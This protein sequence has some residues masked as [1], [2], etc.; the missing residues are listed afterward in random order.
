[1]HLTG[2]KINEVAEAL[3]SSSESVGKWIREAKAQEEE[4][5]SQ[6]RARAKRRSR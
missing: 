5:R 4:I 6:R 3:E 2:K 1:M